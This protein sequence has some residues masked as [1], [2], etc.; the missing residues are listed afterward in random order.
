MGVRGV[1]WKIMSILVG[2][3]LFFELWGVDL[4][5]MVALHVGG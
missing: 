3:I 2:L 1:K 5:S 4:A